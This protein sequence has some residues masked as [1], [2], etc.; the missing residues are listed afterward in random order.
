M[1]QPNDLELKSPPLRLKIVRRTRRGALTQVHLQEADSQDASY[2][3]LRSH[4]TAMKHVA[5]N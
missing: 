2:G 3:F 5:Q 1:T 4:R